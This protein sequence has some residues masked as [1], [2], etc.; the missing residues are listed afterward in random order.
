[1]IVSKRRKTTADVMRYC[2]LLSHVTSVSYAVNFMYHNTTSDT[3]RK[4]NPIHIEEYSPSKH[5]LKKEDKA[6]EGQL[7][8]NILNL[9]LGTQCSTKSK[10]RNDT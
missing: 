6:S 8:A 9:I 3:I 10:L 1:M 7:L 5:T 2:H 4:H